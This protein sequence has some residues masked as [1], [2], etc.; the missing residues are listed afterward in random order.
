MRNLW[1][2]KESDAFGKDDL[3]QRVYSSR[4]LGKCPELVLHGG[5]NTSV[6]G[7]YRNLFGE[8]TKTLFIKGSGWDLISIEKNGFAP[9]NLD[10]LKKLSVLNQLSDSKNGPRAKKCNFKA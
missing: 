10:I 3:S 4:L 9:V 2:Q 6:K 5:G 8:E 1:N 7:T